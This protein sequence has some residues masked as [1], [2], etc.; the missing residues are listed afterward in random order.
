MAK[1]VATTPEIPFD[2]FLAQKLTKP[3]MTSLQ[4]EV[5]K[6]LFDE[7]K[8]YKR[9]GKHTW[10]EII[11]AGLRSYVNYSERQLD[12]SLKGGKS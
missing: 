5:D 10:T 1:K 4:V 11:E 6:E 8:K 7:A 9:S 2:N 12:R 3:E